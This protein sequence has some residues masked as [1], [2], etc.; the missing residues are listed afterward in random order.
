MLCILVGTPTGAPPYP[1]LVQH[2]TTPIQVEV[3]AVIFDSDGVLVDS[4]TQVMEAWAQLADEFGIDFETIREPL[5]GVP[6]LATIS[7]FWPQ[8]LVERA[9]AR[10]EDLE[11]ETAAGTKAIGGALALT[12]QL[13]SSRWAIATSATRRLAVARWSGA[14]ITPPPSTITADDVSAGK[15]NPDPFLAAASALGVD[16]ADTIVFEDSPAG[17]LA[18]RAAGAKV[19][20]VGDLEWDQAVSP[21]ARIGDLSAVSVM[22]SDLS[23]NGRLRLGVTLAS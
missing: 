18:A 2:T 5:I 16:P 3:A 14:G 22:P 10:L 4:H 8:H 15:P 21:L 9:V 20:A 6:A 1:C 19:I 11:V 12:A 13:V 23:S 7:R 17:G